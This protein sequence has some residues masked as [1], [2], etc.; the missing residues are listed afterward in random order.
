MYIFLGAEDANE[1][2]PN[3]NGVHLD[4]INIELR[5]RLPPGSTTFQAREESG[6]AYVSPKRAKARQEAAEALQVQATHMKKP[7]DGRLGRLPIV[8]DIVQ[9]PIPDI[10]RSKMDPRCLTTVVVEV[11]RL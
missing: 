4:T 3:C 11:T 2:N 5:K 10:D 9:V 1:C 8:E 7:A 6:T